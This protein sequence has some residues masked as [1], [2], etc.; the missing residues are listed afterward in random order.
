MTRLRAAK[1]QVYNLYAKWMK[2]SWSCHFYSGA[3]DFL[4]YRFMWELKQKRIT[5]SQDN[6]ITEF[7][8]F[9]ITDP[10]TLQLFIADNV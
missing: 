9:S 8:I 5:N 2:G 6:L 10:C 1:N 4:G 3:K 7:Y